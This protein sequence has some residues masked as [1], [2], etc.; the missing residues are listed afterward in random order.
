MQQYINFFISH[1][2]LSLSFIVILIAVIVFEMRAQ[3]AGGGIS[4]AQVIDL[5]NHHHAIVVDVRDK[6]S[7][8]KGH[9]INSM[10]IPKETL[11]K[12]SA[13]L[14]DYKDR[15]IVLVCYTGQNAMSMAD[16]LRKKGYDNI[17]V[18]SGGIA[19][20]KNAGLPLEK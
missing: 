16:L 14:V 19:E 8:L 11:E 18:L 6:A 3:V 7:F 12:E 20:W 2:I 13:K 15:P 9:I 4:T 17:K 1:W 10:N 5:I